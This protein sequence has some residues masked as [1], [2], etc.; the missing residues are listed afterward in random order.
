ME[1]G[2]VQVTIYF[3]DKLFRGN[4][5]SKVTAFGFDAFD[6]PN[7]P[8]LLELGAGPFPPA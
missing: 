1:R 6:S 7:M 4:R 3:C 5:T 8:P 2:A